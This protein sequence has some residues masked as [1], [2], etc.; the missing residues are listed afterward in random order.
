MFENSYLI[1][2]ITHIL[3]FIVGAISDRLIFKKVRF[4][5]DRTIKVNV[6]NPI[7]SS[8]D[9]LTNTGVWRNIRGY[10]GTRAELEVWYENSWQ[11]FKNGYISANFEWV[12]YWLS[13]EGLDV[14]VGVNGT[15]KL[16]MWSGGITRAVSATTNTIT[17]TGNYTV[18][19]AY[20]SGTGTNGYYF[21]NYDS[22]EWRTKNTYNYSVYATYTASGGGGSSP[23]QSEFWF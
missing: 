10:L 1:L 2:I 23:A 14:L 13:S 21:D 22:G 18:N 20:D 5:E 6:N 4:T 8:F 3:A 19:L 17:K 15:D 9:W 7:V 11:R 16:Y 12:P